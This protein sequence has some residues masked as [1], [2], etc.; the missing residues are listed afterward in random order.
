M[1]KEQILEIAHKA[2]ATSD[3]DQT[4]VL[5]S[6]QR[7]E[8]TRFANSVIHQNTM[9]EDST[10]TLR[11]VKGKKIGL[12]TTNILDAESIAMAVKRA[13]DIAS[14]SP[15]N[16]DFRTLPGPKAYAEVNAYFESTARATPEERAEGVRVIADRIKWHNVK[17]A[18]A[19]STSH[20]GFA[21]VNSLGVEAYTENTSASLSTVLLSPTSAG[22][23][24]RE[25]P[26]VSAI[27]VEGLTEEALKRVL[28]GQNPRT[29]EVKEMETIFS[30]YAVAEMLEY[31][32]YMGL[33]ALSVQEERSFMNEAIGKQVVSEK[34]TLW[35][36]GLDPRGYPLPIDFEG[37]PKRKVVFFDKGVAQEVAYDSLTA[38]KEGKESTGHALPQPNSYGPFPINL[39]LATGDATL[40]DMIRSTEDGVLVTRFWYVR[41]VHPKLTVITG[42]TRDGTFKVE[43]GKIAYPICNLRYT[44]SI[45][46][47]LRQTEMVGKEALLTQADVG[48]SDFVPPLKVKS[49]NFTGQTSF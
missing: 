6:F 39:F 33:G 21:V 24:A 22:Y 35:D 12:A 4:E 28:D 45:L 20:A 23:A 27:D 10:L 2:M 40:E 11:L 31:L 47:S 34:I 17:A 18:G 1:K 49:F 37:Q 46:D 29:I 8:L 44:A 36:D 3:A 43:K 32:A 38:F 19:F 5:L 41:P 9:E 42:M 14:L 30:P 16:N 25:S 7:R 48:L 13:S 15:E 26:D